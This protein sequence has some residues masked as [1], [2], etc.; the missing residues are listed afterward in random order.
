[1]QPVATKEIPADLAL[2]SAKA[3]MLVIHAALVIED[4]R[5]LAD[6]LDKESL[7]TLREMKEVKS[8]S[9]DEVFQI[10]DQEK[11]RWLTDYLGKISA[12]RCPPVGQIAV[13]ERMQKIIA[14]FKL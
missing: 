8:G 1:M 2:D 14:S 12:Y 7:H 9:T 13:H 5:G 11:E 6:K 3:V 4:K 10:T